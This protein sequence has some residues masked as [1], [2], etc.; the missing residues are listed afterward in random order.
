[1]QR[2]SGVTRQGTFEQSQ[3]I[4]QNYYVIKQNNMP[5]AYK[6]RKNEELAQIMERKQKI[7]DKCEIPGNQSS[8]E[9]WR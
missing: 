4:K 6:E 1:M 8:R 5:K 3:Q 9:I 2:I 7:I